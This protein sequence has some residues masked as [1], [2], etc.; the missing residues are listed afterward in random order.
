MSYDKAGLGRFKFLFG[1]E[2]VGVF[3]GVERLSFLAEMHTLLQLMLH[4]V[5]LGDDTLDAHEL[6]GQFA[7]QPPGS[8]K[9]GAQVA[10]ETDAVVLQLTLEARLLLAVD[11]PF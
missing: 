9:I 11:A 7:A 10:L 3:L 1:V 6:V 2:V 4:D 5:H 8:H